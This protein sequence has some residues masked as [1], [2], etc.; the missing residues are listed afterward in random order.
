MV[1]DLPAENQWLDSLPEEVALGEVLPSN[2]KRR[3]A[4]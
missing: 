4:A 2:G 1:V 3:K